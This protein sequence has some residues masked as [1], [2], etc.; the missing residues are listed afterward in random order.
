MTK[1]TKAQAQDFD[2]ISLDDA[3]SGGAGSVAAGDDTQ[4]IVVT[5]EGYEKLVQELEY[6]KSVKRREVAERLQEAISY[7]DLSENSEY[8]DAKNEQAF[9]EGRV[10]ELESKIKHAQVIEEKHRKAAFVQLGT[11]VTFREVGKQKTKT[12]TIVGS[13]ETDITKG[14]ISN[15]SPVGAALLDARVGDRVKAQTPGG[16]MEYEVMKVE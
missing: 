2:D 13:T 7:G 14:R 1:K 10:L 4:A 11:T 3:V 16:M 8:E 12:F 5:R 9:V 15:V 6:L